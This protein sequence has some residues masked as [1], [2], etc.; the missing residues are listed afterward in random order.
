MSV[1]PTASAE[2]Q[3]AWRGEGEG[4]GREWRGGKETE[5]GVQTSTGDSTQGTGRSVRESHGQPLRT[6][7]PAP[8]VGST[9]C[10]PGIIVRVHVFPSSH[11]HPRPTR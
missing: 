4:V 8:P 9:S 10:V 1:L 6:G 5:R 3:G 2:K 11:S 7:Q